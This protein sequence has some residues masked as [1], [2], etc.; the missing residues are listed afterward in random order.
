MI[1]IKT[2]IY[3]WNSIYISAVNMIGWAPYIVV[4]F[5]KPS[6]QDKCLADNS[7]LSESHLETMENRDGFVPRHLSKVL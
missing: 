2:V 6:L 5:N 1:I 3:I 7:L 4:V